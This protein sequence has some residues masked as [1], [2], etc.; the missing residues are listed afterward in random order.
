[1]GNPGSES[2]ARGPAGTRLGELE[3]L[4]GL[5][6]TGDAF[7]LQGQGSCAVSNEGGWDALINQ[8][9]GCQPGPLVI[10][11]CLCAVHMFQAATG[12]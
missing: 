7:L 10:G 4:A 5:S 8:L 3:R 6:L 9:V 1:M 2:Q 12:M 11:P